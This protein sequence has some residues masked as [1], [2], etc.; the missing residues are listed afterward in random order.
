MSGSIHYL[1][2]KAGLAVATAL[3]L[4][5]AAQLA[6]AECSAAACDNARILQLY[7]EANGVVYV[8]VS[9]T[10]SNLNCTLVSGTFATLTPSSSL[11]KEIYASLLAAQM[12]DRTMYVRI[13]T[14]SAGCTIQYIDSIVS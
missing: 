6:S 7:T 12:A 9:G 2:K 8:Q 1:S 14:G 5:F 3:S 4:T 10:M 11:F 13:V